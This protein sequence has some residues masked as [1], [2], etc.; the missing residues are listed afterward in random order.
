MG[1]NPNRLADFRGG[2]DQN[3]VGVETVAPISEIIS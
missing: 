2:L 1:L 3:P